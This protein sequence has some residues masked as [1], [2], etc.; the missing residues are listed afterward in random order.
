MLKGYIKHQPYLPLLL[1]TMAI[2]G[3]LAFSSD[4]FAAKSEEPQAEQPEQLFQLGKHYKKL[5]DRIRANDDVKLLASEDK[6]QTQVIVFFSYACYW[7]GQLNKPFDNWR[8]TRGKDVRTYMF[9][10]GFNKV[11]LVLAKAYFTAQ[12]LDHTGA[13]DD[14]IYNAIHKQ[15]MPLGNEENLEEFFVGQGVDREKFK[16]VY[17]SFNVDTKVKRAD[18]LSIAFEIDAT[19]NIIVNGVK[20]TYMTNL[21]MTKD[22]E[23]LFAVIDYLVQKVSVPKAK[24]Q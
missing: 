17:N 11:W 21:A 23:T 3:L 5:P 7:C 24:Q 6:N 14:A 19:P 15:A 10:V 12:I 22:T 13:L 2:A 16:S 1:A 8:L 9:P 4:G 20:G 18:E